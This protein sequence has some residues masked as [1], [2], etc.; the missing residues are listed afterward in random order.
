MCLAA[1]S[2]GQHAQN[3]RLA[4][5]LAA[6]RDEFFERPA[7]PL[8]WWPDGRLGG[9]DERAGGAWMLLDRAGRLALVTNVREPGRQ[10][11]GLPSRG[12]LPGLALGA[13]ALQG[14]SQTPRQGFNLVRLDALRGGGEWA[15]NRPQPASQRLG[16]GLQGVSNASLDTPWP[17]LQALKQALAAALHDED[18]VPRLWAALADPRP[19]PEALLPAT[20]LPLERER[21]LSSAF[22]RVA[23]PDGRTVYGTRASTL[24]LGLREGEGLRLQVWERRWADDGSLAGET[25]IEFSV[26]PPPTGS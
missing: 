15:S 13:E 24:V 21:Q 18:P 1:W 19:A 2:L 12:E 22:I 11:D 4:L 3:P 7:A 16:P 5:L 8:H 20:G 23:G 14:L 10:L 26:A 6:N 9:R 17:K 25:A